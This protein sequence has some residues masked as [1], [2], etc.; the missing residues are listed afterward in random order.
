MSWILK[1]F[2]RIYLPLFARKDS[3]VYVDPYRKWYALY[4]SD[5]KQWCFKKG[6][7]LREHK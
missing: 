4:Y 5:T 2:Y 7:Y 6:D 1:Q 3:V